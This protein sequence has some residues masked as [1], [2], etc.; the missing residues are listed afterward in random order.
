MFYSVPH[1]NPVR[2]EEREPRVEQLSQLF[3]QAALKGQA[4]SPPDPL[5]T[6]RVTRLGDSNGSRK[7]L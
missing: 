4:S 2:G 3:R 5:P 7:H 6:V 1:G